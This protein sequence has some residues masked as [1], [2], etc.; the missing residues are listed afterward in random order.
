[1]YDNIW[2]WAA[3]KSYSLHGGQMMFQFKRESSVNHPL[4]WKRKKSHIQFNERVTK[5][6]PKLSLC[7]ATPINHLPWYTGGLS[8]GFCRTL[9]AVQLKWD[10]SWMQIGEAMQK[11]PPHPMSVQR[12][13][14]MTTQSWAIW[15]TSASSRQGKN[16]YTNEVI[17]SGC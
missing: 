13:R 5:T 12:S 11:G 7:A 14:M 8:L 16:L 3:E 17:V 1:M 10:G 9:L 6:T 2:G 15:N 4:P